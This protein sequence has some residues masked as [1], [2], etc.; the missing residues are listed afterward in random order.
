MKRVISLLL[1]L[2]LALAVSSF[3]VADETPIKLTIC[4]TTD[5]LIEDLDT[6]ATTLAIEEAFGVDL[7]FIEYPS[8]DA[9]AKL[10]VVMSS[11]SE[12][13][14]IINFHLDFTTEYNYASK[15]LLLPL[16][17]YLDDPEMTK[18]LDSVASAELKKE[19]FL[20]TAM[21]DGKNYG[22]PKYEDNTW[23]KMNFRAWINQEWLDNLGLD[24][25]KTTDEF[26]D[27]LR[28]FKNDDPNGNGIADEIP[29]LGSNQSGD[30]K[31]WN[32]LLN[33]FIYSTPNQNYFD[34]KDGEIYAAFMTDAFKD[35]LEW[36]HSLVEEGLIYEG[37]FTQDQTQMR[38]IINAE[39]DYCVGC[40]TCGSAGHWSGVSL[41]PNLHKMTQLEP[42]TGPNGVCYTITGET[43]CSNMWYVTTSC[44]NPEVAFAIG[45]HFYDW[46]EAM[47]Q[48]YG[49][50]EVHWTTDP[51]KMDNYIFEYEASGYPRLYAT[52]DDTSYTAVQN[53]NWRAST[54]WINGHE[55]DMSW[56]IETKENVANGVSIL[57]RPDHFE[58]Y[59]PHAKDEIIGSLNY[60]AEEAEII[61]DLSVSINNYVNESIV[62]FITGNKS[63]DEW[64]SYKAEI[65]SMG[66]DQYIETMQAAYDRKIGK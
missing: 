30:Q 13:P 33:A 50:K 9:A 2:C 26:V 6:N 34:V 12:M 66:I 37:S 36:I 35:G 54:P 62:A 38:A 53:H 15:G 48:R 23:N 14:D 57:F 16:N 1:T 7:E 3:A 28:A 29:L 21:P 55:L 60:I 39:G 10:A 51:E 47:S 32:F 27:V 18:N 31:L 56:A 4:R 22:L 17:E 59:V 64:D 42:L 40:V 49:I 44:Q 20:R 24:M 25:P 41:N 46:E 43:T 19:M 61:S 52:L 58:R 5:T 63:F 45:E 11:G 8:A 65:E